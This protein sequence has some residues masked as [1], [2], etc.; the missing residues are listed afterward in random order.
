V[1]DHIHGAAPGRQPEVAPSP[2]WLGA[3]NT[4]LLFAGF[5]VLLSHTL[6]DWGWQQ[7]I[8]GWNYAI[9]VA[10]LPLTGALLRH[11]R[12]GPRH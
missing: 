2:P 1:T 3:V 10:P 5:A 8:G 9:A 11:W 4:A 6:L 12:G 7:R